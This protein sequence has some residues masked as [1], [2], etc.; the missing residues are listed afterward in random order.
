MLGNDRFLGL[1]TKGLN[2]SSSGNFLEALEVDY[3]VIGG[4]MA[5][6]AFVK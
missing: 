2:R 4:E 6:K 3:G 1:N 5:V